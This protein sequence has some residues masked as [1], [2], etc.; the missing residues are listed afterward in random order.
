MFRSRGEGKTQP[1]RGSSG[2]AGRGLNGRAGAGSGSH[3]RQ[4]SGGD[5]PVGGSSPVISS[6]LRRIVV[7]LGTAL[8][9][10]MPAAGGLRPTLREGGLLGRGVGMT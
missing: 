3:R 2:T 5:R 6:A 7:A 10:A 4:A 8:G 1:Y 9:A